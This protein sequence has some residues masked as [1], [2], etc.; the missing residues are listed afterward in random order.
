VRSLLV[1]GVGSIVSRSVAERWIS[2]PKLRRHFNVAVAALANEM[3]RPSRKFSDPGPPVVTLGGFK[4]D[5][6]HPVQ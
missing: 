5:P 3:A 1:H 4:S 2:R 6:Q